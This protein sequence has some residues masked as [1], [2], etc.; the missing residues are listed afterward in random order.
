MWDD[1]KNIYKNN[2]RDGNAVWL[3]EE[4]DADVCV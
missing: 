1:A 3:P 4:N 2:D